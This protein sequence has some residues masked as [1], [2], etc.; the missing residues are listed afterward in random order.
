MIK[1]VGFGR[2]KGCFVPASNQGSAVP[3]EL[4]WGGGYVLQIRD[5]L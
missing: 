1:L 4:P 5:Q 2:A 3:R